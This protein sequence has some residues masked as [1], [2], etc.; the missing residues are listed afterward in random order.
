ML[1]ER[2]ANG[3]LLRISGRFPGSDFR[4]SRSQIAEPVS[5]A[6]LFRKVADQ[7]VAVEAGSRSEAMTRLEALAHQVQNLA[8]NKDPSA[9]RLLHQ[10]R[11]KFPGKAAPGDKYIS[12]VNDDDMKF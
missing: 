2:P 8:L 12:V 4:H 1:A 11:K 10:M 3:G 6:Y 7:M 9:A 5:T